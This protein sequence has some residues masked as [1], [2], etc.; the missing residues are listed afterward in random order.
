LSG[1]VKDVRKL[2]H[3]QSRLVPDVPDTRSPGDVHLGQLLELLDD[4]EIQFL[5]LVGLI[6]R[7]EEV[8]E[9]E[10]LGRHGVADVGEE[11]PEIGAAL[12]RGMEPWIAQEEGVVRPE[13]GVSERRDANV[14]AVP[15]D[16]ARHHFI[17]PRVGVLGRDGE[18]AEAE[19]GGEQGLE[20]VGEELAVLVLRQYD[21]GGRFGRG[22]LTKDHRI[23]HGQREARAEV[24]KEAAEAAIGTDDLAVWHAIDFFSDG[25]NAIL[26]TER[27]IVVDDDPRGHVLNICFGHIPIE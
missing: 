20:I 12:G 6:V 8:D 14:T 10:S 23:V 9:L 18:T 7:E 4:R 16:D 25:S 11:L 2:A 5:G 13:I 26:E 27:S 17:N 24:G 21:G 3:V 15:S 19:R 1:I 22:Q